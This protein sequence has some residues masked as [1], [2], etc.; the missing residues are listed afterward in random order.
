MS[1]SIYGYWSFVP[2]QSSLFKCVKCLELSH[3]QLSGWLSGNHAFAKRLFLV[4]RHNEAGHAAHLSSSFHGNPNLVAVDTFPQG[5]RFPVVSSLARRLNDVI[6]A[7]SSLRTTSSRSIQQNHE[8]QRPRIFSSGQA[9]AELV[10]F[11]SVSAAHFSHEPNVLEPP[12]INSSQLL[13]HTS[14]RD[15]DAM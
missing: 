9:V 12:L 10:P 7:V 14:L 3:I 1:S 6:A 15:A 11:T 2:C 4:K 8:T 5:L 13:I